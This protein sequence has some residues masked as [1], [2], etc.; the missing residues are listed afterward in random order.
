M[1]VR[2]NPKVIH[3]TDD[4]SPRFNFVNHPYHGTDPAKYS[5]G[6]VEEETS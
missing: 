3:V 1:Y 4:L 6:A 2:F 5:A